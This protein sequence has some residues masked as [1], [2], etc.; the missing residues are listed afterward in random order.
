MDDYFFIIHEIF[1]SATQVY[2]DALWSEYG[3]AAKNYLFDRGLTEQPLRQ[4]NVGFVP[5]ISSKDL[6]F[7]TLCLEKKFNIYDIL[8]S[9]LLHINLNNA[10]I[11]DYFSGPRIIFPIYYNNKIMTFQTRS[12]NN[13][14]PKYLCM[15]KPY[16]T[17]PFFNLDRIKEGHK[18]IYLA[19]GIIDALLLELIGFP[20]VGVL[21]VGRI[22]KKTVSYFNNYDGDIIFIFDTDDNKSGYNAAVK[23]CADLIQAGINRCYIKQ[24]PRIKELSSTDVSS[25]IDTYG[26]WKSRTIINSLELEKPD[27]SKFLGKKKRYSDKNHNFDIVKIISH[28]CELIES[29]DKLKALCPLKDHQDSLPS[30]YVYQDSNSAHCFGCLKHLGPIEFVMD[31][32]QVD[33]D[34]A[35]SIINKILEDS[36]D[37][38]NIKEKCY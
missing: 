14:E 10:K 9:T 23:G 25:L 17:F 34:T 27:I 11:E 2:S 7:S 36:N 30:F 20:S 15:S 16:S 1:N 33:H 29:G 5:F 28:Y 37:S 31:V 12:I 3:V 32:E 13:S 19:E 8:R 6:I 38:S 22:N 35:I 21:G 18:K 26:P 24:I 4:N